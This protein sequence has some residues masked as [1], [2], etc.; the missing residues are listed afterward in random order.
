MYIKNII[1]SGNIRVYII[2][3]GCK[4]ELTDRRC[5]CN[6]SVF[7]SEEKDY[8]NMQLE[9]IDNRQLYTFIGM[10]QNGFE[11]NN[12]SIRTLFERG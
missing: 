7:S 1:C 5:Q 6:P 4:C 8:E 12:K 10:R 11:S 2:T 3:G 9:N